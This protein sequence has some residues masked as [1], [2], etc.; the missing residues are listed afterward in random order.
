[1]ESWLSF[2]DGQGGEIVVRTR[3]FRNVGGQLAETSYRPT[4][5]IVAQGVIN[6]GTTAN[7]VYILTLPLFQQS[8]YRQYTDRNHEENNVYDAS[9]LKL[10]Q[11]SVGYSFKIKGFVG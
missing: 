10:R 5:G 1:L 6:T 4:E 8:Y 9:F 11:F 7:P 2:L 3:A